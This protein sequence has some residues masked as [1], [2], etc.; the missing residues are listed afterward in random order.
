L[1]K[2][3]EPWKRKEPG[4]R[5]S[6]RQRDLAFQNQLERTA[7]E[8]NSDQLICVIFPRLLTGGVPAKFHKISVRF[9]IP[10]ARNQIMM[11]FKR[12]FPE[13]DLIDESQESRR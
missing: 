11:M 9:K 12:A 7:M 13:Y 10:M 3:Y 8:M 5:D 2:Q 4:A 1:V 6:P